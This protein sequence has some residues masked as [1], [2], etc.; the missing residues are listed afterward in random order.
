VTTLTKKKLLDELKDKETREL[1]VEEHVTTGIPF[2]IHALREKLGLT[3]TELA[4]RAGMAQERVSKLEDP[5][6]E[7]IP[8]IPT[9]LK[10][11]N[12]FDVPLIVRFGSWRN[13][14]EW[15]TQ[16]SPADLAP[17]TFEEEL[18]DLEV[19]AASTSLW[20]W[21]TDVEFTVTDFPS[22]NTIELPQQMTV[23]GLRLFVANPPAITWGNAFAIAPTHPASLV[24]VADDIDVEAVDGAMA[25]DYATGEVL[26]STLVLDHASELELAN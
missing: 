1:F 2:Q 12:V 26:F 19:A 24:N 9:L 25:D 13:L 4:K 17:A 14:F 15:E 8:K 16:L 22:I 7:F 3:Q 5:N 18:E 6:Y 11:A 20:A 23:H 21:N 10:L